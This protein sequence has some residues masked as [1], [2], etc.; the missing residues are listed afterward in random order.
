MGLD[1][2]GR[3]ALAGPVY[4]AAV[5]MQRGSTISDLTDSKR[6]NADARARIAKSIQQMCTTWAIASADAR[7]IER[8]NIKQASLLA[9]RRACSL[10]MQNLDRA[11]VRA[12]VDGIDDPMLNLPTVC[13]VK[14]D[15]LIASVS[16]ASILAKVA[17]DT[18]MQH[19]SNI[20]PAYGFLTNKG[21]PTIEHLQALK[22]HMPSKIHRRTYR[23]VS[24]LVGLA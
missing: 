24:E 19:A 1:E 22:Q 9:M 6:L 18:F 3:G 2:A 23:H 10:C 17:R 13:L 8:I 21:Y 12:Y 5:V 20:Y 4:A 11:P 14:G 15:F 7:E 16:A